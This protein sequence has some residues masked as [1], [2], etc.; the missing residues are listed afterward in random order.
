MHCERPVDLLE[1]RTMASTLYN[2]GYDG[3]MVKSKTGHRSD[4][5]RKYQVINFESRKKA[6]DLIVSKPGGSSTIVKSSD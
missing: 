2:N 1:V 5:M 6:S 4:A 3:H